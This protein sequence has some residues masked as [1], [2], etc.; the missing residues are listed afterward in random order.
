MRINDGGGGGHALGVRSAPGV[1][2]LPVFG[3]RLGPW[4]E[5]GGADGLIMALAP[6]ISGRSGNKL[7]WDAAIDE[8]DRLMQSCSH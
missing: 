1:G 4:A 2:I 7:G 3:P 6:L 5:Q 8:L